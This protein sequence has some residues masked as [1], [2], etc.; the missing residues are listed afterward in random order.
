MALPPAA[1][2]AALFQQG[3]HMQRL[4]SERLSCN[5]A[6]VGVQRLTQ[7]PEQIPQRTCADVFAP[8]CHPSRFILFQLSI[9]Q[10]SPSHLPQT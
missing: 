3:S 7:I 1:C 4:L 10:G 5:E 6:P 8:R 9:Q 2:Q